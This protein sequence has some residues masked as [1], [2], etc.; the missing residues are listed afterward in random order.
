MSVS[1]NCHTGQLCGVLFADV[2]LL[3]RTIRTTGGHEPFSA[4]WRL[5]ERQDLNK[6]S[7]FGELVL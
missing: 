6:R 5:M 1:E 2:R 3:K 7:M 4:L